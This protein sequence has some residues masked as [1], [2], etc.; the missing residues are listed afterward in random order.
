MR[1]RCPTCVKVAAALLLAF[2]TA[3]AQPGEPL[4][5]P[6]PTK[7]MKPGY[8]VVESVTEVRLVER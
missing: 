4:V 8:G 6:V 7:Q 2:G 1:R 3:L 5:T